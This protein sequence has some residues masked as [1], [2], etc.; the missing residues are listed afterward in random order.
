ML[1]SR[2]PAFGDL[3][4]EGSSHDNGHVF[5]ALY[6]VLRCWWMGDRPQANEFSGIS[7]DDEDEG[8]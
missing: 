8:N 3:L 6:L 7:N 5:A 1:G 2:D 4:G